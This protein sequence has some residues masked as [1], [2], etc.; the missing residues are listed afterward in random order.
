MKNSAP[1]VAGHRV[2]PLL[3]A[4]GGLPSQTPPLWLMRQ[5][6]RFLPEYRAL[7]EK[8]G[9]FLN[10]VYNPERAAEVTMQPL[11]RFGM[12]AVI[13]FSDILVIPQALGVDVRFTE[14]EGPALP[15]LRDPKKIPTLDPALLEKTLSPVYNTVNRVRGMLE[16]EGYNETTLIGFAGAPWTIACYMI[17]GGGS[18]EFLETKRFAYA[19]PEGFEKLIDV[20]VEATTIYLGRQIDEG[21]EAAQLF[22]SWAGIADET[23][24][25]S[26]VIEPTRAIA[27]R[28]RAQYPDVP[29][30]GFPR[31]AGAMYPD[32][33][34]GAGVTA[35]GLD[36]HIPLS[37]AASLQK[38]LPVQGNLDP[39]LLLTGGASMER[40]IDRI[41]EALS[42]G[43]LVF[44]LGHGV[45]KDTPIENVEHLIRRVRKK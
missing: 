13:L 27:K 7:R 16:Q 10:L 37:F 45:N 23:Q 30:I 33:A 28:I 15:P 44:N 17:E 24:F 12:D 1:S 29:I 18:R 3:C 21:A 8:A 6:G 11:R 36:Q 25:R 42:G 5:A 26:W 9:A 14:G 40:E 34:K 20:I 19:D 39:A 43:P 2:K 41:L 32:Y 38:T 35:M 31:G 22:D 4:L